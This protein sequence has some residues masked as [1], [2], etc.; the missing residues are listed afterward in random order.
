M[1][2]SKLTKKYRIGSIHYFQTKSEKIGRQSSVNP[3]KGEKNEKKKQR[4]RKS[5]MNKRCK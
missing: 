5:R 2:I 4:K 1:Y 3:K